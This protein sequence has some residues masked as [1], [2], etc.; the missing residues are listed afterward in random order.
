MAGD[1]AGGVAPR[2]GEGSLPTGRVLGDNA[3]PDMIARPE[4]APSGPR[5]RV[6]SVN[7]VYALDNLPR[8]ASLVRHHATDDPADAMIVVVAG[9]FLAPSILSSLDYGR[10]MV[11][12]LGAV[13]VTHV[14]FGNHEDDIPLPELRERVRELSA[15]WIATNVRGF[16]PP[17]PAHAIVEV[18]GNRT[19]RVGLVGVVMDD[20]TAYRGKPFGG[21]D[22]APANPAATREA[23]ILLAQGCAGVVAITHQSVADD[24]ALALA[25]QDPRFLAIIGGHEHVVTDESVALTPILKAGMDAAHAVIVDF[26]WPRDRPAAGAPDLPATTTRIEDVAPYPEDA[27]VRAR[28]DG[29]MRCVRDLEAATLVKLAPGEALSSVGAR[30]AQTSLGTL[31]C[32]RLRDALGAEACVYNGGGIRAGRAYHGRLTYGDVK[33]ELPFDNEVVVVSL[34]G[35]VL[36]EAVAA[37]RARAPAES[38]AFLQIDDRMATGASGR[39]LVSVAG[40]PLDDDR[41]YAV[42][43][44]RELLVGMDH[45]EP[46]VRFAHEHPEK[47]PPAGSGREVKVVLVDAFSVAL[48]RQLGGFD[49][50]DADHD[51]KVTEPELEAAVAKMTAEA[52]S[53]VTADLVMHALDAD[54]DQVI[55]RADAETVEGRPAPEGE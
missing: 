16:D 20:A 39:D 50:V 9:D 23:R 6:V 31:V 30:A 54:H 15:T 14:I 34:P 4:E 27:G 5:L 28:V 51:G 2:Q 43:L 48:W 12:C 53:H 55:S 26:T 42:A 44:V 25:Q 40:A 19:V 8:L 45:I 47:V 10:G 29:H 37:S 11:D 52:P 22:V 21:A 17:L 7:D 35:R 41:V 3:R 13:G 38:G 18:A 33:A 1:G 36:R 24:R 49:A 32:S 46:L